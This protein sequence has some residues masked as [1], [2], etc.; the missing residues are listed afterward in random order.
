MDDASVYRQV[1]RQVTATAA[2]YARSVS[3]TDTAKPGPHRSNPIHTPVQSPRSA[4]QTIR[5]STPPRCAGAVRLV[6]LDA[7]VELLDLA[8][9][10]LQALLPLLQVL[11]RDRSLGGTC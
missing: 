9:D 3:T 7:K 1:N 4:D 8:H 6:R 2:R 5:A 10:L 11:L